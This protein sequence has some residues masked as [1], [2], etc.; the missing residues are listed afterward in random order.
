MHHVKAH[1]RPLAT[2]ART[3]SERAAHGTRLHKIISEAPVMLMATGSQ[4]SA[5]VDALSEWLV[6]QRTLS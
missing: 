3:T 1:K 2:K 5:I 6:P 4:L